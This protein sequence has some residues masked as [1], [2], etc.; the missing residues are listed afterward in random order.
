MSRI[1]VDADACPV[2]EEIYRVARRCGLGVTL[3]ANAWMRTP[4]EPWLSLQ[5]V[6]NDIDA[7]DDWIVENIQPDDIV[8]TADIHLANRCLKGGV[9]VL[10][11]TGKAFSDASI[12][13]SVAMRDLLAELRGS[14]EI[15]G[16]PP[17]ISKR[18]RSLFL[19]KLN[20]II[21]AIRRNKTG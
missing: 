9:R 3:V 15:T 8:I 18:D 16:G 21:Q 7:A 2:K 12:G 4:P 5:L 17:P 19:Q 11:P 13:D 10:G 20:E 1:L 6:G 14:G